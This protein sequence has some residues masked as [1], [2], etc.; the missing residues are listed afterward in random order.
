[1]LKRMPASDILLLLYRFIQMRAQVHCRSNVG[2]SALCRVQRSI[3]KWG[4][5]EIRRWTSNAGLSAY[6]DALSAKGG[7]VYPCP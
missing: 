2:I 7:M 5:D 3:E 4:P 6:S 1:M